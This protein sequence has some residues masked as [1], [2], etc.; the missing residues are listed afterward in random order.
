VDAGGDMRRDASRR[1]P[2]IAGN[3]KKLSEIHGI[4]FTLV[5]QKKPALCQHLD[6]TLLVSR[7]VR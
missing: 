5:S 3:L 4:D 1:L 7:S 2:R 6:F